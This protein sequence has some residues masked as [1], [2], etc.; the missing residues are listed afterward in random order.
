ML[1]RDACRQQGEDPAAARLERCI[2]GD[3]S[4]TVLKVKPIF[5]DLVPGWA[6]T[7]TR[8]YTMAKVHF[9]PHAFGSS[10]GGGLCSGRHGCMDAWVAGSSWVWLGLAWL[11][12]CTGCV[13]CLWYLGSLGRFGACGALGLGGLDGKRNGNTA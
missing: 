10:K 11:L 13:G 1:L 4:I 2:S 3:I 6:T 8:R 5:L 12:G 7:R 9:P